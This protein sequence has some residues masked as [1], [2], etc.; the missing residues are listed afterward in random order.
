MKTPCIAICKNQGGICIGCHR[1]MEEIAQWRT[2]SD[3]Q[4][5]TAMQVLAGEKSTHICPSCQQPAH[6]D[7]LSGHADCWCLALDARELT[8]LDDH[9]LCL[10]R[11]CLASQPIA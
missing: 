11:R 5:D 7:Q 3:E 8:V 6:C 1:T 9:R 2:L 4:R 10:C